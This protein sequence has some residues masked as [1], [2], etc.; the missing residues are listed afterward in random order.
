MIANSMKEFL[1]LTFIL[2]EEELEAVDYIRPMTQELFDG[3]L[4]KC[5]RM[6]IDSFLS[7]FWLEYPEFFKVQGER[8]EQ[9][10]K[11]VM[12]PERT[13]E[14]EEKIWNRLCE[15]ICKEFDARGNC[16]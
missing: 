8:I 16:K 4:E 12:L 15:Q 2:S 1:K 7:D 10:V 14:E 6:N 5:E 3:I 9:E 11:F 13:A